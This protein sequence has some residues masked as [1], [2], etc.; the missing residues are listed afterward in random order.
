MIS[1]NFVTLFDISYLP[2][3]LALHKSMERCVSNFILWIICVDNKTYDFLKHKSLSNV[4]LIKLSN[5]ETEKMLSIKSQRSRGEYCWTLAPFAPRFVFEADESVKRVTYV[6][7]DLWF[8]KDPKLILDEFEQSKKK[9]LITEHAYAIE[10]DQSKT[11]GKFCVQFMTFKKEGGEYVRKWWEERCIEWCFAR[12]EDGKFGDQKYLDDWPERFATLVHV[13][14]NQGLALGPWNA[15]R[16]SYDNSVFY[17][18]HDLKIISRKLFSIGSYKLPL[19]FKE[20][21]YKPYCKDLMD[22]MNEIEKTQLKSNLKTR[23]M[24]SLLDI[25]QNKKKL[26]LILKSFVSSKYIKL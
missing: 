14:Q 7:A 25:F 13:L 4:R 21:V 9:V 22:A 26:Y 8:R 2:Q 19:A 24:P 15:T 17:H 23:T 11:S 6:D 3:G 12:V 20:Y 10:Y 18:F 1:E 16:F 5:L